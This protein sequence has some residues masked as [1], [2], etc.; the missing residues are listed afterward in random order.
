MAVGRSRCARL[1][2]APQTAVEK[3][4]DH[5][6]YTLLFELAALIQRVLCSRI[7]LGHSYIKMLRYYGADETGTPPPRDEM[8]IVV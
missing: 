2:S 6:S 4:T 1:R 8:N 3:A 5:V 7:V